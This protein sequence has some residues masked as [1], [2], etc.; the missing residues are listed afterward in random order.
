MYFIVRLLVII[1]S[2]LGNKG[3]GDGC[4]CVWEWLYLLVCSGFV[5]GRVVVGV[6]WVRSWRCSEVMC[7]RFRVVDDKRGFF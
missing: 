4:W 7:L 1:I 3:D 5:C 6:L 2:S